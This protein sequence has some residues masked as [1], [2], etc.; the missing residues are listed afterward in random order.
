MQRC[1]AAAAG[2][3]AAEDAVRSLQHSND[4]L[5]ADT[6][7][8][9]AELESTRQSMAAELAQAH[10]VCVVVVVLWHQSELAA[11]HGTRAEFLKRQLL[12]TYCA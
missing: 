3:R 4:R 7:R 1:E 8:L 10:S 5:S 12:T 11:W 2:Q 6:A 9:R